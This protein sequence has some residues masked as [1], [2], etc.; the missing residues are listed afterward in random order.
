MKH[1]RHS[2][3]LAAVLL[4]VV[5]C[6]RRQLVDG[7]DLGEVCTVR[8]Q[9]S[10]V[11]V[12]SSTKA[13]LVNLPAG[14]TVRIV[15]YQRQSE[16]QGLP[17]LGSDTWKAT[18]TYKVM[19]DGSFE[20]CL[21]DD[22]GVEQSGSAADMELYNGEYDFY[23]YSTARKLEADNQTV[24]G[25]GHG[26]DFLGTYLGSQTINRSSSTVNLEFEHECSKLTFS[27]VP[28]ADLEC[29][30]LTATKVSMKKMATTPAADYTIGGDLTKTVGDETSVCEINSFSYLDESQ[31]QNGAVGSGIFLPKSS[32]TIP[33]E[34]TVSIDGKPYTLSAELPEMEFT[35]GNNY[36]FTALVTP[37]GLELFLKVVSWNEVTIDT[38]MGGVP[39]GS[40]LIGSWSD[41]QW[42]TSL[43]GSN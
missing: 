40:V 15:A 39:E 35:K 38:S 30:D 10:S 27:V 9:G 17:N 32:G 16:G 21:V 31:K 42:S 11:E 5:G 28:S 14:S 23:A 22:S 6:Q 34:F 13:T 12:Q 41:V 20:P 1:M 3:L 37:R 18:S 36:K 24:K 33:A 7:R 8:F 4:T 19:D 29:T 25:V 43:G 26:E 2:L